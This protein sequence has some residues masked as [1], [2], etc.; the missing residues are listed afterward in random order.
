VPWFLGHFPE[1]QVACVSYAQDLSDNLARHSRRLMDSAFYQAL[2]G[3]RISGKRDTVA[4]FE[5]TR[6]GFRFSTSVGGGFTGRGADVIVIDDAL[7]ADESLSDARRESVNEWFDNTLRSRLNRQ[8]EGAIII[9][10]QRLHANDLVAHVQETEDWRVLSFPAIAEEDEACK[11]RNPYQTGLLHRKEGDILQPALTP[12][13]VLEALRK[14]MTPYHFAAQYQQ[15]PQPPSGNIVKREWL[16]FYTPDEMPD[17]FGT[18]LQSWDTAVKDTELA[19]FS[20]CTTWGVKG[21]KAYLLDVFRKKLLFP[22]LK[23]YVQSLAKLHHATV[24]LIEDMSS[25]SSLIQQLRAEGFSK[26]RAAPS[27]D[28]NKQMRLN[29]QTPMIEGGFVLFP[30]RADW[31]DTYLSELLSF[32]SVNY[33]DQ[34]DSTVYALAWIADNPQYTGTLIKQSSIHYYTDLPEDKRHGLVFASWDTALKDGGQGDWTVCTVWLLL[35]GVYYLLHMERG[36]YGY[37]D[38]RQKFTDLNKQ[39]QPSKIF[40]EE[41]TIGKSLKGARNLPGSFRIKLIPIEEDRGSR[42]YVL[43]SMFEEGLVQF[44]KDAPFMHDLENELLSYPY[45]QTNDIVDSI[46]LALTVGG[47]GYDSSYKWV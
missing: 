45:G 12:R 36:L 8:L 38:L 30:K 7:K 37:S 29:G 42:V 34:V 44:P 33:D 24:V 19:K 5:T 9:I 39:Y 1:K 41:T 22:D 16:K 15:N 13:P 11:I 27:L 46:A 20:V 31:L 14:A 28:G 2:F 17:E 23:R 32:P 10:M 25:G 3:T 6:G 47:S 18:I 43:Q 40:I 4:H 26:V 21:G 35:N